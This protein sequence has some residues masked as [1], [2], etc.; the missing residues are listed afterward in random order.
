LTTQA[1]LEARIAQKKLEREQRAERKV[2]RKQATAERRAEMAKQE[3]GKVDLVCEYLLAHPTATNTEI[4]ANISC[5]ARTA[6]MARLKLRAEGV[7]ILAHHDR[8]NKIT[9]ADTNDAAHVASDPDLIV[10][11]ASDLID[12]INAEAGGTLSDDA[13]ADEMRRILTVILRNKALD[14]R[15]RVLAIAQKAKLDFETQDRDTLG[16]G[17]PLTW[18]A[19]VTRL[20]LLHEACG[21]KMVH[22]A[23][24][25]AFKKEPDAK[26]QTLHELPRA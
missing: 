4:Y 1:S 8:V 20:A 9:E 11:N 22:E 14:P 26:L 16:P 2:L 23:I 13:G 10:D 7:Q 25:R 19:G 3:K 12:A 6:A 24:T 18:E 5:S 17:E 15:V 21:P